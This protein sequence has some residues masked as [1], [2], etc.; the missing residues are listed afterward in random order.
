MDVQPDRVNA[1][2]EVGVTSTLGS[3]T[4]IVVL[5]TTLLL[6]VCMLFVGLRIV[7]NSSLI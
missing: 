4:V 1:L 2:G 7:L 3:N 5:L 6:V